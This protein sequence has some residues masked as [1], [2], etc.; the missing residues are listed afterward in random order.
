MK[1]DKK[2]YF[3]RIQYLG[4]R[5]HGWMIQPNVKTLQGMI[6]RTLNFIFQ[7]ENFKT[8]GAG[9]TDAMVSTNEYAFELFTNE[10]INPD[11]LLDQMN[12][13]FP[14]DIRALEIKEVSEKF[15]IML[16]SKQKEYIYLFSY[17]EK[18]HPFCAP[19]MAFIKENLDIELMKQGAKLFEGRHNFLKYC[20][21][22]TKHTQVEREVDSC[23]LKEN[24][25][26]TANFFPEKSYLLIV[27]GKG[28]L[29]YQIRFMMGV[30]FQLGKH[31]ITL[32]EI[33]DSLL[34]KD[35]ENVHYPAPAS[36][37]ML[38]KIEFDFN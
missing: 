13:N 19:Y 27:K 5:Y 38:N 11:E 1:G 37:L 3:V 17:G 36:G 6:H 8:L 12:H 16:D 29:R 7:H 30:L 4:F 28:F 22:P 26:Y 23:E 33:Q 2:Y 34:G 9:R 20:A 15:N 21:K 18:F 35:S 24:D 14:F 25:L 32:E 31:Q 10:A